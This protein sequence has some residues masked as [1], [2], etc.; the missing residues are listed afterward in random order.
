MDYEAA[1]SI[2]RSVIHGWDPYSLLA[3]GAPH[4]EWD[5]EIVRV[6]A[7]VPEIEAAP[8]AARV[9]SEVF[10]TAFHPDEFSTTECTE[11]GQRLY[12]QLAESGLLRRGT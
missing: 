3:G 9:V 8:D 2:V 4:D 12:H 7:R 1:R 10:S 5:D 6:V 11:V